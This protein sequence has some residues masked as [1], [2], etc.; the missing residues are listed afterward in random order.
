MKKISNKIFL[1]KRWDFWTYFLITKWGWKKVHAHGK[2]FE[3]LRKLFCS[4]CFAFV[5]DVWNF[6]YFSQS[7]ISISSH[8]WLWFEYLQ[9]KNNKILK[10]LDLEKIFF[11]F[12]LCW[13]GTGIILRLKVQNIR[14]KFWFEKLKKSKAL[15]WSVF[16]EMSEFSIWKI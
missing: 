8:L 4:K 14:W 3:L 2:E 15:R 11:A 5:N 16:F 9:K 1:V 13:Q 6:Q 12:F 7:W 10:N